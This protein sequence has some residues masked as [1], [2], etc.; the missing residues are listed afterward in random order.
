MPPERRPARHTLCWGENALRR[1]GSD[2]HSSAAVMIV[3]HDRGKSKQ[4]GGK[5]GCKRKKRLR[6]YIIYEPF[7]GNNLIGPTL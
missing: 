5:M 3:W 1:A 7:Q 2:L 4:L 6:G